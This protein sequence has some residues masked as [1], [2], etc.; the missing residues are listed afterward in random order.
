MSACASRPGASRPPDMHVSVH[1][2]ALVN[3]GIDNNIPDDDRQVALNVQV[4]LQ[5]HGDLLSYIP[6][7]ILIG[8]HV[9]GHH[10]AVKIELICPFNNLGPHA[11]LFLGQEQDPDH[12]LEYLA[13]CSAEVPFLTTSADC[14]SACQT[15]P[16]SEG[17]SAAPPVF[18][19][20]IMLLMSEH[21]GRAVWTLPSGISVHPIIIMISLHD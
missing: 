15:W 6:A 14:T 19:M 7:R 5:H 20:T 21:L 3:L 1:D 12:V 10:V 17:A 9:A 16:K 4:R 13:A 11:L 18:P 2:L 8:L